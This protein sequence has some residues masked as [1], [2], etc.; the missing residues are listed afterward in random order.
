MQP[1]DPS[2]PDSEGDEKV[3]ILP[4]GEESKKI[5]QT[6]SN[7]SARQVLELLADEP[8]S[9]SDIAE[10]L[11]IP[12]TTVKYNLDALIES[13][14]IMIK[15]T[16]WSVK[17]RKIKIYSPIRKLIVVVPDKTDRKS[18]TD[19]LRRYL[20]VV[21]GAAGI[22]AIIEWW[23]QPLLAGT[24]KVVRDIAAESESGIPPAPA[25]VPVSVLAPTPV[26]TPTPEPMLVGGALPAPAPAPTP[27][28]IIESKASAGGCVTGM[29]S[30]AQEAV[31]GGA[32]HAYTPAQTTTPLPFPAETLPAPDPAFAAAPITEGAGISSIDLAQ[33]LGPHPGI[34]FFFGCIFVVVLLALIEYRRRGNYPDT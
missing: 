30:D 5:T 24:G 10:K 1:P 20:G 27:V 3:L 34:W 15:Q 23:H 17:G 16:R 28:E 6:L 12:L 4:L 32:D 19:I 11:E 9:A 13:G 14:L 29:L 8:M 22:S 31:M 21:L 33:A 25:A 2:Y 7:D 26:S 18:V